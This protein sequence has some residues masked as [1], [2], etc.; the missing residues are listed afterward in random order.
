M[1]GYLLAIDPW[2]ISRLEVKYGG[3][4]P[5]LLSHACLTFAVKVP[6]GLCEQLGD[7]RVVL[8][9]I[10]PYFMAADLYTRQVSKIAYF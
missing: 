7:V 3:F 8:L 2:V 1:S 5:F 4:D 9:K 10:I 6:D